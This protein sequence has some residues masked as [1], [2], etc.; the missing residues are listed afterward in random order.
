V[1]LR[2]HEHLLPSL[3]LLA[4]RWEAEEHKNGSVCKTADI[5][6]KAFLQEWRSQSLYNRPEDFAFPY[7]GLQGRKRLDLASLLKKL[8]KSSDGIGITG[9]GWHKFRDSL[10]STPAK[11]GEYQLTI[12][13]YLR[14]SNLHVTNKYQQA[15]SKT[16]R[17]AQDELVEVILPKTNLIQ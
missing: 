17:S 1:R 3:L 8:K 2:Q 9:V 4:S 7:E 12:R 6:P 14:H 11:L 10:G 5:E 13:N 15:T 16:K